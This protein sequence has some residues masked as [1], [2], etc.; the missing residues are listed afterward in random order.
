MFTVALWIVLVLMII[1]VALGF[2][3]IFTEIKIEKRVVSFV[4]CSINLFGCYV[5]LLQ[6]GYFQ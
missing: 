1:S 3:K 5:F 2:V 6:L 4:S